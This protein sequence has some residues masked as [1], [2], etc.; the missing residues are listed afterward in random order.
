MI[1]GYRAAT[2]LQH[3]RDTTP[4]SEALIDVGINCGA[5][6]PH[7]IEIKNLNNEQIFRVLSMR[8]RLADHSWQ[9]RYRCAKI[10]SQK[11]PI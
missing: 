11:W 6:L 10:I 1:V 4:I 7:V 3:F 2:K 9:N 5:N 8:L